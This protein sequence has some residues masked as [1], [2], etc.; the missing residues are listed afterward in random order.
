LLTGP[1][2]A[3]RNVWMQ[4]RCARQT[5]RRLRS[6]ERPARP[7]VAG[8]PRRRRDFRTWPDCER[9]VREVDAPVRPLLS[10]APEVRNGVRRLHGEHDR[11][12]AIHPERKTR[13]HVRQRGRASAP[14]ALAAYSLARLPDGSFAV[15]I[16]DMGSSIGVARFTND[17]NLDTAFGHGGISTIPVF[18]NSGVAVAI[19]PVGRIDLAVGT[20]GGFMVARMMP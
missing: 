1:C 2:N 7:L 11:A 3:L 18:A 5:P 19:D 16:G 13:H 8:G 15:A 9:K 12:R 6:T 17:G 10:G 20:N 14:S 4:Q